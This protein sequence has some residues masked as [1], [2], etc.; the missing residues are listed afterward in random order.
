MVKNLIFIA[1][2]IFH[3]IAE[4]ILFDNLLGIKQAFLD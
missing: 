3:R 2:V 1:W 4:E